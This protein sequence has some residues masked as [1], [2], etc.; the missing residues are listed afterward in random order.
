MTEEKTTLQEI[1]ELAPWFHNLH[2]PD[3]SQ[4]APDHF[5][6]DFPAFKWQ[7][8]APFI[9]ADLTGWRALDIGCNA[10]FYSFELARRG[11]RVTGIDV[12]GRYLEQ[13][14]WAAEKFGLKDRVEF[15]EMQVYDLARTQ[16]SW[17]LVLFMGVFYHLRY[18]LLALDIIAQKVARLMVFQTLTLPGRDVVDQLDH[19]INDRDTLLEA[20][21]PKMAFIEH[22]FAGDPTN[23]WIPNHAGVE[24]MLRSAGLR[25][26]G[27]PGDEMYCC[28]PDPDRPSCMTTWNRQEFRSATN[29]PA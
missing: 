11:A 28:E 9:P 3:G 27:Y 14:R 25:I 2:L 23:W 18:P 21:W 5:L 7:E 24:A 20:G 29:S 19:W 16:D 15:R 10:G 22:R 26:T 4:T 13:A 12:D 1:R 8:L 17:D 6:G